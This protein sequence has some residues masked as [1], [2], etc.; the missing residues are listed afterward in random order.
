MSYIFQEGLVLFSGYEKRPQPNT[1]LSNHITLSSRTFFSADRIFSPADL[2][3]LSKNYAKAQRQKGNLG[4]C[5][6]PWDIVGGMVLLKT[7][8]TSLDRPESQHHS[9]FLLLFSLQMP[10]TMS[11][12]LKHSGRSQRENQFRYLFM[13]LFPILGKCVSP[14]ICS[15]L[16]IWCYMS[17]LLLSGDGQWALGTGDL[18]AQP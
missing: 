10:L 16:G 3:E 5:T 8:T 15:G 11:W 4:D 13:T 2:I 17:V 6:K 14:H 7:A 1:A 18:C 9:L 12:L